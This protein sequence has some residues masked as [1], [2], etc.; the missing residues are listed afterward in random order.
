MNIITSKDNNKIK[1]LVRLRDDSKFRND[2]SLFYVEGERIIKDIPLNLIYSLYIREENIN[3]YQ[4]IIDK[5]DNEKV[6]LIKND[7]FDKI[8]DTVNSQ[9]IIAVV[10]Y[11]YLNSLNNLNLSNIKSILLLDNINDPGNLGTILRT[12]E[13]TKI[14]LVIVSQDSCN[15][16]NTKV[17]RSCMSS[18]FRL[19][20]LVS[21]DIISDINILRNNN[22]IIYTTIVDNNYTKFYDVDFKNKFV[23]IFGNEANGIKEDIKK[24]S[25]KKIYIPMCGQIESLNVSISMS[26]IFYEVMKQNNYYGI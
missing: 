20:I 24:I 9:G 21:N 5:I 7:V 16:Y 6:H 11:N 18:I 13:A 3:D 14:D 19:K 1:D 25:D 23:V 2:K 8:K 10:K 15:I 12:A 22:F 4:Y 26:I 17:I